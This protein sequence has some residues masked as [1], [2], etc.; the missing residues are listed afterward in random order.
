M[1][2]VEIYCGPNDQSLVL[3]RG[4]LESQGI[5]CVARAEVVPSVYPLSVDGLGE[6]RLVVSPADSERARR[7][8]EE[9]KNR[10]TED[11]ALGYE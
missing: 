10:G 9:F 2:M 5:E 4:W 11:P 7:L 6:I 3:L 1:D 8:V